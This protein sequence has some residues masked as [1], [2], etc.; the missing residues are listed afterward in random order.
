MQ[1]FLQDLI[2]QAG[3]ISLDYRDR[4]TQI[5]IQAKPASSKDLVTE[6]D[7]AIETFLTEAILQ[8]YPDHAIFGEE[9][10]QKAGSQYRWIIDPIDGTSS[11]VHQQPFYSISVAV[12][13][14]G[15]PFLGAVNAPVMKE[16]FIAQ[17]GRGAYLNGQP[18]RVSQRGKLEEA[19]VG[20]GFACLRANLQDNN[21]PYF[22]R[23]APLARG[24]RRYGSAAVDLCYVACGRLDAFWEMILAPYD[25]AAGAAIL[26]EAGGVYTDFDGAD[27]NLQRE[28]LASN[29][30][31][32]AQMVALLQEVKK[33]K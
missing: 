21:L 29:G 10:G 4:L 28:T 33:R 32:H 8:R 14:D 23:I 22:N 1:Q 13:K 27:K 7:R 9:F 15:R 5:D 18:I 12:E 31:L 2:I 11:F 25:V 17:R 16:L 20:T 30:L 24:I 19:I 26:L 6:A 3:Q